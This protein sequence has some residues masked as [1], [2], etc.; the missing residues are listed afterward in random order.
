MDEEWGI[1]DPVVGEDD[2]ETWGE[3]DPVVE[4]A[5][6]DWGANDPVIGEAEVATPATPSV[7]Q[8]YDEAAKGYK[9][10][11]TALQSA[12]EGYKTLAE[13]PERTPE[14]EAEMT[15]QWQS[16]LRSQAALVDDTSKLQELQ[17]AYDQYFADQKQ[18][19]I[20]YIEDRRG[21]GVFGDDGADALYELDARAEQEYEAA[22][23]IEDDQKRKEAV[24]A[25]QA[26][27]QTEEKTL[28]N[29]FVERF[30][31]SETKINNAADV[32]GQAFAKG[33][34]VDQFLLETGADAEEFNELRD[35]LLN[36]DDPEKGKLYREAK[37]M[38]DLAVGQTVRDGE[39]VPARVGIVNNEIRVSPLHV[40]D[41]E[42]IK[43]EIEALN[44]SDAKKQKTIASIPQLQEEAAKVELPFLQQVKE[45]N[46]FVKENNLENVSP[47]RQ[48]A[49]WKGREEGWLDYIGKAPKQVGLGLTTGTLGLLEA[50]QAI[51]GA[52]AL[53]MGAQNF[54]DPFLDSA[55][56]TS[57]EIERLTRI[58][59]EIG[60]PTLAAEL[61]AV[62]PQI[63]TQIGFGGA[64]AFGGRKIGLKPK[65]VS[66]VG[67]G[68]S[69]GVA[70]AQ[71]YG[72]VL[73]SAFQQLEKEKIDGGMDPTQARAEAV[74]EAQL[75]AALS[76]LSTA[77][78]T[79]IGGKRGAEAVFRQ[80]ADGIKAKL[81]TAAFR[82]ELDAFIP[83]V[84]KGVRNEGYEEFFDQLAQGI[85][86]QAT[87]NP[88]LATS[89]IINNAFKA[90]VIGGITGGTVEG[91][92]YGYD[93]M[94]V[95]S[96]TARREKSMASMRQSISDVE[97][98]ISE[99]A[100]SSPIGAEFQ[101]E[102]DVTQ[103]SDE[104]ANLGARSVDRTRMTELQE[105]RKQL[106]QLL[107][108]ESISRV[109]RNQL[110]AKLAAADFEYYNEILTPSRINV[111]NEQIVDQL[112]AMVVTQQT[113]DSVTALAKIANG[114][115][116]ESLTGRERVAVGITSIGEGRFLPSKKNPMVE[117][118]EQSVVTVT[119]AGRLMAENI[120]MVPLV[121]MIGLSETTQAKRAEMQRMAEQ[122]AAQK[123]QTDAKETAESEEAKRYGPESAEA[124]KR[125]AEAQPPAGDKDDQARMAQLL[126]EQEEAQ[127]KALEALQK[128]KATTE[129]PTEEPPAIPDLE[130]LRRVA[131]AEQTPEDVKA[132]SD[133]GLVE[134]YKD[135][136]VIT[137]AGIA[138]LP[139]AERPRLSPEARKIQIDTGA[140]SVVAEAISK[141][142]RIGV[143]Q[144]GP[145]VTMP[146]GWTLDGDIYVPPAKQEVVK[147]EEPPVAPPAELPIDESVT[148][149]NYAERVKPIEDQ[150]DARIDELMKG[151]MAFGE[152]NQDPSVRALFE[153]RYAMDRGAINNYRNLV[154][155]AFADQGVTEDNLVYNPAFSIIEKI[156]AV[157]QEG[158]MIALVSE[159]G[160][161]AFDDDAATIKKLSEAIFKYRAEAEGL[162]PEGLLGPM[163]A[164]T[165]AGKKARVDEA[166]AAAEAIHNQIKNSLL[167]QPTVPPT[168]LALPPTAPPVAP[169]P[170]AGA[171][172]EEQ[173]NKVVKDA[174]EA[175]AK[176][177]PVDVKGST[178]YGPRSIE[179]KQVINKTAREALLAVSR[180]NLSK[181]AQSDPNEIMMQDVAA[182]LA[183]LNMPILDTEQVVTLSSIRRRGRARRRAG[184]GIAMPTTFNTPVELFV[185]EAG[186]T[187][188]ADEIAKYAPRNI[189][190]RGK[191]YLEAINKA[192]A[193]P[194]TPDPVKRLFTLYV[195][196]MDQLGITEQYFGDK[197]IAGTPDA[198]LS[199]AMAR[200]LQ[201][202]GDLRKDLNWTQLYGLANIEEFVSQTFSEPD[203]RDLLKTLKDPTQPSRTL[204]S[205]FVEAIQ[206]ILQ[207]PKES[208]A[209]GVIEASV[210][211]G[212]ITTPSRAAGRAAPTPAPRGE[213]AVPDIWQAPEQE[214]TSART[215]IN[216]RK[217]PAVFNK[218]KEW[219]SGTI[220]ADIGGGRFDNATNW[221]QER[222]V[223]NLIIDWFNRDR[224]FNEANIERVRGG[225]ADTATVSN[226][227]N[228]I[229]EQGARDL[230]IRQAADA[231]KEDGTA[232][233]YIYEG[234]QS[235]TG[236][237]TTS[238]WQENRRTQDY[239]EDISNYFGDVTRQG[240]M[241]VAKNPIKEEGDMA[242]MGEPE[243]GKVVEMSLD[244]SK[245]AMFQLFGERMYTA[246][247]SKVVVKETVQNAFDGI[248]DA[249]ETG[250]IPKGSGVITY[251]RKALDINGEKKVRMTFTD[252]GAGMTPDI[253]QKAFFTVGGTFK[254]SGKG[255]GGFG[256][257]KLGMFMS[258]DRVMVETVRDGVKS[259]ADISQQQLVDKKF[260]TIVSD[261]PNRKNGTMVVLEFPAEITRSDGKVVKFEDPYVRFQDMVRHDISII[262][263][264][265]GNYEEQIVRHFRGEA[266]TGL[267]TWD[268]VV[269]RNEVKP[270]T[271]EQI[272]KDV[273]N[274]EVVEKEFPVVGA[275]KPI[276][277]RI[278]AV[279][280][281]MKNK[282]GKDK[283]GE[284]FKVGGQDISLNNSEMNVYSN[285]L[286]QFQKTGLKL[287]PLELWRSPRLPYHFIIDIDA[288]GVDAKSLAYPFQNNREKFQSGVV[289]DYV[290]EFISGVR[291]K[292]ITRQFDQ[293]FGLLTDITGGKPQKN[294]PSLYNNT[295]IV[296]Q[297]FEQK[298]L[299]DLS[300]TI[301][302]VA[303]DIVVSL[304]QGY[305]DKIL[306]DPWFK[307]KSQKGRAPT[308]AEADEDTLDYFYGVGISKNWGGVNTSRDPVSVL[309]NPIYEDRVDEYARSEFGR[310]VLARMIA[311]TLIHEINHHLHR[312]EGSDFTFFL[313]QNESYL[314]EVGAIQ[315]AVDKILPI[316]NQHQDAIIS[317]K[318]KFRTAETKDTDNELTGEQYERSS[319]EA[320]GQ[321]RT[322]VVGGSRV[323]QQPS[324]E[325]SPRPTSEEDG[326]QAGAY[327]PSSLTA[328]DRQNAGIGEGVAFGESIAEKV[329]A[330]TIS[331]EGQPIATGVEF[332]PEGEFEI[333]PEQVE[334]QVE[335]T[336]EA[337]TIKVMGEVFTMANEQSGAEGTP[338][339]TLPLETITNAW[340]NSGRDVRDLENAIIRYTNLSPEVAATL[341]DTISKQLEI[342]RGI[343]EVS[344]MASKKKEEEPVYRP[345]S[346]GKRIADELP[347]YMQNKMNKAYEVLRNDVSVEEANRVMQSMTVE[348]A[349]L[350][351][352][353][354]DNGVSMGVRSMMAQIVLRKI[355]D[356]RMST[357]GKR[358]EE[359]RAAVEAHVDFV[360]WINEYLMELGQGIQAFARFSDLGADGILLKVRKDINK[361]ISKH[362]TNRKKDI[363]Q[364]KK[365]VEDGDGAAFD[366]TLKA[367]N[368][369]IDK[370]ANNAAK[371]EAKK[372][373]IEEQAQ[374]LAKRAAQKV[375][376]GIVR[377]RKTDPLSELVNGHL[378]KY[379]KDFL[380]EARALGVS[381]ET[382]QK[383]E[384][385][386]QKLRDSRVAAKSEKERFKD[387]QDERMK[388]KRE[389]ARE[390]KYIYGRRP[391][392]WE[393]YQD[394]FSERL[395][396][397]LMRDPKK[398]IPPSLLLFTDRLTENILGFVPE[399]ERQA[400]TPKSF[401][402][403][404]EDA[405]NNRERYQEAFDR[406][407]EDIS[408]KIGELEVR[409]ETGEKLGAQYKKALAAQEFLQR[410]A[411]QIQDFPV[412]DKLIMRFVGQKTKDAKVSI[413][414][415]YNEWYRASRSQR[416]KLEQELAEGLVSDVNISDADAIKLAQAIV[417]DFRAKA[418]ERREKALARFKKPK[419][420]SKRL[421][422][423]PLKKFF[424]L[425]NMGAMTD[426]EAYEVM[427]HRFELP[428]W[429]EKFAEN[430][431]R[432]ALELQDMPEGN[433]RR[434][435]TQNLMAEIARKKG[436]SLADL[437]AGFIYSNMLSD[438][439][440]FLIN[441][442]DTLYNNFTNAFASSVG[443]GD[444]SRMRGLV[445]GYRKGWREA[446]Y[447]FNTGLR[448]NMP[449]LE[450]RSPLT[451]ELTQYGK[452]GGIPLESTEGMNAIA[453]TLLESYPAR[454]LNAWKYVTRIMEATD[455][456]NYT[457]SSEGQRYAEAA[458]MAKDEGLKGK[459]RDKRVNEILNLGDDKY[460]A[461]LLQ[462]EQEGYTGPDAKLRAIEIQDGAIEPEM[463][464][465]SFERAL[466]DVYR[467]MPKGTAGMFAGEFHKHIMKWKNPW[468]RNAFKLT[469]APFVI[470][471]V[472]LFN[473]W[474]DWSPYGYKRLFWG[475]GSFLDKDG[476]YYLAPP[477]VGSSEFYA[478]AFKAS[479]SVFVMG[480][481]G[482]LMKAGLLE[483]IGR[484]PSDEEKR[485]QWLDENNKPYTFR[486]M[487]GPAISF[488]YTPWALALSAMANISNW[489]KYNKKEDAT[490]ADRSYLAFL[491]TVG[492]VMELP[493]FS[494][495]ADLIEALTVKSNQGLYA[496]SSRFVESKYA[497]LFPNL[498]RKI[499]NIFDPTIYD[500]QGIKG[501]ILDKVPFARRFGNQRLNMFG[502]PIG[503]GK[504]LINRFLG[505]TVSIITPSRE[506]RIL[507]KYD[508]YPYMPN[509]RQAKALV[510]GERAQM[511]EEQ[512][513]EF[514]RGAGQEF[515]KWLNSN[516]DPDT[517]VSEQDLERGKK[518]ISKRLSEIRARWVRQVSTY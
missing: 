202:K 382:A 166:R 371:Q 233:F 452:K 457:A 380:A 466:T 497:M 347:A 392:I 501:M 175:R 70:M 162:D 62:V 39:T 221:L 381:P 455:A 9:E 109:A 316:V 421:A 228:I 118:N 205:A 490:L 49:E 136:P 157:P 204:W 238:G 220:N 45:F 138:A 128:K 348:E 15:N 411:P 257:A 293:T 145:N 99:A 247:L 322:T 263:D 259:V 365:D 399:A 104:A 480:L 78:V 453:K 134:V 150:I 412:S 96:Q 415:K 97:K 429:D 299:E 18:A 443:D 252:N 253:L 391:T 317:L 359:Y 307:V 31:E 464:E 76:G 190:G 75:P 133:A 473:K 387:M 394:V 280:L 319:K 103:P 174:Q 155:K 24:A 419:E 227:L 71:S 121:R 176:G 290:N 203:F 503:E 201:A 345:F 425:V 234:D 467:N 158:G 102:Y 311:K 65:T 401:Q 408:L 512:Y 487:G 61:A 282:D 481:V 215:S 351:T 330:G 405:L 169:P 3:N 445:R 33:Q 337:S 491:E 46:N 130:P 240:K 386:A 90:L 335:G 4:D 262:N 93:Y 384:D 397:R 314:G 219:V 398:K 105:E 334:D 243:E 147:A 406:A 164:L 416:K 446:V 30:K 324:T 156:Y 230:V 426:Q 178:Q 41:A 402:A 494:G 463:R 437:G 42:G 413:V 122:V 320:D 101:R 460:Q 161:E 5:Q 189:T 21:S 222:G 285:G 385:S 139:E 265:Y 295:T 137:E 325:V 488:A 19:R 326:E 208:M 17:P 209:A 456:L 269:A 483:L 192:I 424:E 2:S 355:M 431:E 254:R 131:K 85:I 12:M 472:N 153:Q 302:D 132:L 51:A 479:S 112:D 288:G 107:E 291:T 184:V 38:Y 370:A 281:G 144:V 47:K 506:S 48:I 35:S 210:D 44:I 258:A 434:K 29:Q 167:E 449:R 312:N 367:N 321:P 111:I 454:V 388:V 339:G 289:E 123:A 403:M 484:G 513:N 458:K 141:N 502:E 60:G 200:R 212:M 303:D 414:A 440:T 236:K 418:E 116:A 396:R 409:M 301:F 346:F 151:G 432:M 66:N 362:I 8:Q 436:F 441:L 508:A 471:P 422:E 354:M 11:S 459:A 98:E 83:N 143:D 427:A 444:W 173:A 13:S 470:T 500:S 428:T 327:L 142:L 308:L 485:K 356:K 95:P 279:R 296:P 379:N 300:K 117:V 329:A 278:A 74:K 283:Y 113:K 197:G 67:F 287:K 1:N 242:P 34:T 344:N 86:E 94:R 438:Y 395:A 304:R 135:Q 417:K 16:M 149:F 168:T 297:P 489:E 88:E 246:E 260:D 100:A 87:F 214:I 423:S 318:N 343:A 181:I 32:I 148:I 64:V 465:R 331:P 450:E 91:L 20:D 451:V 25:I 496:A 146:E 389:L 350:A 177:K 231:L 383:I 518:R 305:E 237:Q 407:V 22:R 261:A 115:G 267:W 170:T 232:Y 129:P 43:A 313:L 159:R 23:A 195:S 57:D 244:A 410:L 249:E 185:H 27:Y 256:I 310:R 217:L 368:G 6:E 309:V 218:V 274:I 469:T 462:A 420:K 264:S 516:Y 59:Q 374:K 14:Q 152:A 341:A 50:S 468:I 315:S 332:A 493:F 369:N 514:A 186:H 461:A 447:T 478:Q 360:D 248:K 82:A 349:M 482:G 226:V 273:P 353:K 507:A 229:Q 323:I 81:N 188:T 492:V 183:E 182:I 198:D 430:I 69:V 357:K 171:L 499:D 80:G 376:G 172:T 276:K 40:W 363:D 89:D 140:S 378:R 53:T 68:S 165:D 211:I 63:V 55:T 108:D 126:K 340:M 475:S 377:P 515:K 191:A 216:E 207:L 79:A 393:D 358:R 272:A 336:P 517:E 292:E 127:R 448:I 28:N 26:K 199:R 187:I 193:D 352:M 154:N 196:T 110:E 179:P 124:L 373:T 433:A 223:T 163:S 333:S 36:M 364:I 400:S 495:A 250:E 251:S 266:D 442:K 435:M 213:P 239:I 114:L 498:V 505:R 225:Q 328:T 180:L 241:I 52:T 7:L 235:G 255:S 284:K 361:A 366:A 271:F 298:F 125:Q 476:P 342:Q 306:E 268:E 72:G 92:K 10:R 224:A 439:E 509:P 511:T 120:G 375:A 404:I 338:E 54:A 286:Y 194:N 106:T 37:A 275:K 119:E 206:R 477:K 294:S 504:P 277:V 390:N 58:S 270:P 486:F 56:K 372:M 245:E 474:L 73:S 84:I 160:Q 510:D 77:I